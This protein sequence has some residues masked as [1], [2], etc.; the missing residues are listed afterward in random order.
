MSVLRRSAAG[1]LLLAAVAWSAVSAA[2]E[3]LVPQ[4]RPLRESYLTNGPATRR[5]FSDV[6]T[7]A[8]RWTVRVRS[9]DNDVAFGLIVRSDGYI[10]TKGSGLQGRLECDVPEHGVLTAE[11]VGYH[12]DHDLA[13]LKVNA[14]GLPVVRWQEGADPAVGRWAVTP[15]SQGAPRSVGVISVSRRAV[16]EVRVSG[17]LGVRLEPKNQPATVLDVLPDSAAARA[18]LQTGDVI[19]RIND[20]TITSSGTLV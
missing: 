5:A 14:S 18:G 15:D 13:L 6:V 12:P 19:T 9:D 8:N 7:D 20:V 3:P 10:L 1:S 17:V 4:V 16:P 11:Y 2:K